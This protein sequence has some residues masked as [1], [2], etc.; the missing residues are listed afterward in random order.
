[1]S[2]VLRMGAMPAEVSLRL[3]SKGRNSGRQEVVETKE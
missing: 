2:R 1:M 3:E